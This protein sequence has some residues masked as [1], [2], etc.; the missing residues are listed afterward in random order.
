[1]D[2]VRIVE[3]AIEYCTECHWRGCNNQGEIC[4]HH[5]FN[6]KL[7]DEIEMDFPSW[8]PLNEV[9]VLDD[10]EERMMDGKD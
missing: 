8:C 6:E 2:T 9:E 1:M 3:Y 7:I 5:N 4:T 10:E